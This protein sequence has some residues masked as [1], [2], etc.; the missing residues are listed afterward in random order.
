MSNIRQ[1]QL[2]GVVY[3]IEDNASRTASKALCTD[4]T[5]K[6]TTSSTSVLELSQLSGVSGNIQSQLNS[7]SPEGHTHAGLAYASAT[8][9]GIVKGDNDTVRI[10]GDGTISTDLTYE[11]TSSGESGDVVQ[12]SNAN[13]KALFPQFSNEGLPVAQ[14]GTGANTPEGARANL[15]V[16]PAYQ[17]S[18]VDLEAGVSPLETGKLYFVYEV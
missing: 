7:K 3:D 5:G 13:G 15:G 9:A 4:S 12:L 8:S 14:G 1:I 6:I 11:V 16:A 17:Y 2:E 18:T 10:A